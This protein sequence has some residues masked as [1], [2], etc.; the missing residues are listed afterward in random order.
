MK[1]T[2]NICSNASRISN[3]VK[4]L[5]FC[6]VFRVKQ[7]K[8]LVFWMP[9]FGMLTS[10]VT[11]TVYYLQLIPNFYYHYC[12]LLVL[13]AAAITES[14][15]SIFLSIQQIYVG[16]FCSLLRPQI[17]LAWYSFSSIDVQYPPQLLF[18]Q[19]VLAIIWCSYFLFQFNFTKQYKN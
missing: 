2:I 15:W 14:K 5:Y 19:K 12:Q 7:A 10:T 3:G 9:L 18:V 13:V 6:W 8:C 17:P 4:V 16:V 1:P 11:K